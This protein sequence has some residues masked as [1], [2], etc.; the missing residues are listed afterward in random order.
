MRASRDVFQSAVEQLVQHEQTT[1]I[2][3]LV[4]QLNPGAVQALNPMRSNLSKG[5][6]GGEGGVSVTTVADGSFRWK[7]A[8]WRIHRAI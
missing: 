8:R 7:P 2:E 5:L 1:E 4:L 6:Q 3:I